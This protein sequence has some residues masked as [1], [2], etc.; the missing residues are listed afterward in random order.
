MFRNLLL[1]C[2]C[3]SFFF[4]VSAQE[5]EF[6]G[7]IQLTDS[8]FIPYKVVL[9][10]DE[11]KISGYSFT[12]LAGNH[13]TKSSIVGRFDS[14]SK[15]LTFRETGV[16]Y[17]KSPIDEYDFCHIYFKGKI[18][19]LKD[20]KLNG[21]FKSYY[22]D[23]ER[24]LDGNLL[25]SSIEKVQKRTDKIQKKIQR[26]S[27]VADSI[28]EKI[29]LRQFVGSYV[30]KSALKAGENINVI[31]KY[32]YLKLQLWDEGDND[33]DKVQVTVNGKTYLESHV[34]ST[35]KDEWQL[36][37]KEEKTIITIKA[38]NLGNKSPNTAKIA[39]VN[40]L[41]E[42]IDLS[43][44]LKVGEEVSFTFYKSKPKTP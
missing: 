13:E 5:Y 9:E 35:T 6:A 23:L 40:L 24:C 26:T 32:D 41:G 15:L 30:E 11:G 31:W 25:M 3:F 28:K 43:S 22:D 7:L 42:T 44:Y 12:D 34:V 10:E 2:A 8:T 27:R 17:T 1:T 29:D 36:P 20:D 19:D 38:L 14:D 21:E 33:N 39:F 4:I 16:V 37:L 18:K